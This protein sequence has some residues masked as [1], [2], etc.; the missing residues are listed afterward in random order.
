M[1]FIVSAGA[2]PAA[3][4]FKTVADQYGKYSLVKVISGSH[5]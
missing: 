2:V 4:V 5:L 1:E 3:F